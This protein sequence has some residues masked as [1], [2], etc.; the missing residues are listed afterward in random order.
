MDQYKRLL[1][2]HCLESYKHDLYLKTVQI[3]ILLQLMARS[4]CD[5]LKNQQKRLNYYIDLILYRKMT[6]TEIRYQNENR[7]N[8]YEVTGFEQKQPNN[9]QDAL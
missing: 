1:E 6:A 3:L 7:Q 8:M 4:S 2:I 9:F 5:F